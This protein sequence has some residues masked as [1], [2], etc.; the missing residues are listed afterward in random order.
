MAEESFDFEKAITELEKKI[1][2]LRKFATS[3]EI[4]LSHEIKKLETRVEEMK[5]EVY[6]KITPWQ[7]SQVARHI[8]RPRSLDYVN[9][10]FEDFMELHGD[11]YYEDD[12]AVIAGLAFLEGVSVV[13]IGLQKGKDT[14]DNIYRNFGMANPEGYR[15]ALR[16]MQLAEKFNKPII[17]FVDTPGAFPGIGS[18]ERSVAEAIAKNLKEMFGLEVPIII[19]IHGE[20]GS[21]GALGIAVGDKVLMLEHSMY[22]VISPEGCAAIL[23]RDSKKAPEASSALKLTAQDLLELGIIDEIIKEPPGGAHR[24]YEKTAIEIKNAISKNLK[25]LLKLDKKELLKS[26]YQKFRN[27][28]KFYE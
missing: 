1:E 28:G 23:W 5:K 26:R 6:D 7:R 8:Q 16:I 20:G 9:L 18:E 4:D 13:I 11:R 19:I 21:G 22:S 15:K 24:N 17:S 27:M 3:K 12:H 10:I 14:K 2:E 25:E